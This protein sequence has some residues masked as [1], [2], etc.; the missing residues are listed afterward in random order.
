MEDYSAYI[1]RANKYINKINDEAN[2]RNFES[3]FDYAFGLESMA[4]MLKESLSN[5]AEKQVA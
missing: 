1:I 3:A 2:K 4:A 5:K